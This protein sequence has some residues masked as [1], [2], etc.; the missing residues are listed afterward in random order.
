MT[1]NHGEII[2]FLIYTLK[3]FPFCKIKKKSIASIA[4]KT[5]FL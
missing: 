2:K 1:D 4:F 5:K 3:H